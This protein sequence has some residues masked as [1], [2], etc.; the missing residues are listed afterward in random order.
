M[1]DCKFK[2][3]LR[4][5]LTAGLIIGVYIETGICTAIFVMLI[6]LYTEVK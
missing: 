6:F 2:T 5:M 4:E 3:I 1:K